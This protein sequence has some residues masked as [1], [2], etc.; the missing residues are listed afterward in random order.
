MRQLKTADQYVTTQGF[1]RAYVAA[2]ILFIEDLGLPIEDFDRV[3]R[4][5]AL[6]GSKAER[7]QNVKEYLRNNLQTNL[8]SLADVMQIDVQFGTTE[9]H[10]INTAFIEACQAQNLVPFNLTT[11]FYRFEDTTVVQQTKGNRNITIGG[12]VS[13][14]IISI[15]D[16]YIQ[17]F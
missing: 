10:T 14:S 7:S 8:K 13:G 15:G 11:D 3:L 17:R 16:N 2:L 4:G 6:F 1:T 5:I 12:A 9:Y